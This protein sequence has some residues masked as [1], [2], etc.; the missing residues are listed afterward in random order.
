MQNAYKE[1]Y[2]G[3]FD[4]IREVDDEYLYTSGVYSSENTERL[5]SQS[6]QQKNG[7]STDHTGTKIFNNVEVKNQNQHTI[8]SSIQNQF[9]VDSQRTEKTNEFEMESPF[10]ANPEDVFKN[11]IEIEE[12]EYPS[13]SS[14]NEINNKE[15]K[16]IKLNTFFEGFNHGSSKTLFG[17]KTAIKNNI[18]EVKTQ[19]KTLIPDNSEESKLQKKFR[20]RNYLSNEKSDVNKRNCSKD[21]V[22]LNT[23]A[24]NLKKSVPLSTKNKNSCTTKFLRPSNYLFTSFTENSKNVSGSPLFTQSYFQTHLSNRTGI[25][26]S[27]KDILFHE[28]MRKTN[29]SILNPFLKNQPKVESMTKLNL[30]EENA[31]EETPTPIFEKNKG[32]KKLESKYKTI[33]NSK[34]N[35]F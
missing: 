33:D 14:Q 18:F 10:K 22:E 26:K 29:Q 2:K 23:K 6:C 28:I 13:A 20:Q 9:T 25:V 27:G 21:E 15:N 16:K 19:Q 31:K 11:K 34:I 32:L 4:E 12:L 24:K 17:S 35:L 1:I 5:I 3:S 8:K 7:I 30:S